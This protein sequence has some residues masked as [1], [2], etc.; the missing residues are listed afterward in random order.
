MQKISASILAFVLVVL[1]PLRLSAQQPVI[2]RFQPPA[3]SSGE[4]VTIIGQNFVNVTNVLLGGVSIRNFMVN[5]SGDTI[6][7]IVSSN[8]ASGLITVVQPTG[9][10]TSVTSFIFLGCSLV[11]G[12]FTNVSP[13]PIPVSS[14]N[15]Q[16]FL[17]GSFE[18]CGDYTRLEFKLQ[19][20][21]L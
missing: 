14:G 21:K 11:P 13:N 7:A 18:I 9:T 1:L 2:L 3:A 19:V 4:T 17:Y 6:R 20:R 8:A 15:V 12:I 16:V 10:A 5:N